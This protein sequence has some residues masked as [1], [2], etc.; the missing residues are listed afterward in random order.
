MKDKESLHRKT[1]EL[2]DCFATTDPMKEMYELE[3]EKDEQ[4]AALKWLALAALYGI[5]MNAKQI[6]ISKSGDGQINVTAEYREEALPSPGSAI[7]QRIIDVIRRITFLEEDKGSTVL[8]L[9]IRDG[10]IDLKVKVKK[11]ENV[12]TVTLKFPE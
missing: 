12:E 4:E 5:N 3:K 8:A 9:G 10:S 2:I 11:K 7:G 6:A 1:Q